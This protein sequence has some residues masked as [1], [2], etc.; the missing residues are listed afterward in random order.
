MMPTSV[1]RNVMSDTPAEP[2]GAPDDLRREVEEKVDDLEKR[3]D[4]V[5]RRLAERARLVR[6]GRVWTDEAA[7]EVLPEKPDPSAD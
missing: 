1:N 7:P 6:E 5:E 3:L 4:D 2:P